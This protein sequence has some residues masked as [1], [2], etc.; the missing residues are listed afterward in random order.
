MMQEFG[1]IDPDTIEQLLL[2]IC[3]QSSSWISG[4]REIVDGL[5]VKIA[6]FNEET[7]DYET[8]SKGVSRCHICE[9]NFRS[10]D[11]SLHEQGRKHQT[12]LKQ[13]S[14]IQ[15]QDIS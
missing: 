2:G 13:D 6:L 10:S 3:S 15:V 5:L 7:L 11:K 14:W 4:S 8:I 12:Y 9:C 1:A